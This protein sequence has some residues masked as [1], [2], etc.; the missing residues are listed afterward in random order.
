MTVKEL[1]KRLV[2]KINQTQDNEIL[3]EMY[4]LIT[5]EEADNFVYELSD[6]QLS[7]VEEAQ[8]QFRNGQYLNSEDAEKDIE[9]WLGK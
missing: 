3:E 5:N 6:E 1:K 7:A 2:E 9:E 4:R 8:N